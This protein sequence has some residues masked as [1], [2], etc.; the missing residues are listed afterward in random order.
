MMDFKVIVME[1]EKALINDHLRFSKVSW[2]LRIPAIYNFCSNL[3]LKFAFFLKSSVLFK[4]LL[5]FLFINKTLKFD[6]L[7][8]W[9]SMNA[10]VSVFVICVEATIYLLLY[11]LHDCTFNIVICYNMVVIFKYRNM[12]RCNVS[13]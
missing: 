13:Y 9:T 2:K 7:K 11:N 10:K 8:I 6:N 4:Y 3:L 12:I 5:S 1:I